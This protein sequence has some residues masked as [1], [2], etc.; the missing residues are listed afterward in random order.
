MK[1]GW[2]R[3][4]LTLKS[5]QPYKKALRLLNSYIF[6]AL[7][8]SRDN[9]SQSSFVVL[10]TITSDGPKFSVELVTHNRPFFDRFHDIIKL[11]VSGQDSIINK[12]VEIACKT[13]CHTKA[14]YLLG[15]FVPY[16][17]SLQKDTLHVHPC[18]YKISFP[19]SSTSE[20]LVAL[21]ALINGRI[22]HI[23]HNGP[24]EVRDIL[25]MEYIENATSSGAS[26]SFDDFSCREDDFESW[27]FTVLDET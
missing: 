13:V 1:F 23:E 6:T 12:R 4:S 15:E 9:L 14:S 22:L 24:M 10:L 19:K 8:E 7:A 3:F 26:V 17:V 27:Y 21:S 16:E 2:C 25:L 20:L 5:Q 11:F 18:P